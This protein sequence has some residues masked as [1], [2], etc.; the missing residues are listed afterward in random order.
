MKKRI[1]GKLELKRKACYDYA[2]QQ[3]VLRPFKWEGRY[4]VKDLSDDF[5]S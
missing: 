1:E 3:Q 4:E 2:R 5:G